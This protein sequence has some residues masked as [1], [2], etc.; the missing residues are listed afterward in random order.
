MARP[1]RPAAPSRSTS[2][3]CAWT[4][5]LPPSAPPLG[6]CRG[7]ASGRLRVSI[8][9]RRFAPALRRTPPKVD[10]FCRNDRTEC[11]ESVDSYA[12]SRALSRPV[13]PLGTMRAIPILRPAAS[14]SAFRGS[15]DRIMERFVGE[16]LEEG[17]R[18]RGDFLTALRTWLR[19]RADRGL[20]D[21]RS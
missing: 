11:P 14:I 4:T 1:L 12:R 5:V 2:L 16:A 3:S 21:A 20:R 10:G 18:G 17:D 6:E 8:I 15:F 7:E 19:A 9:Q 13:S